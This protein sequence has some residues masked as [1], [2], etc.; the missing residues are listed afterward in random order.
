MAAP[1]C[2]VHTLHKV[3]DALERAVCLALVN[4]ALH[5]IFAHSLDGAETKAYVA[6]LVD[7]ELAAR[8]VD[9]GAKYIDTHALALLHEFG[10]FGYLVKVSAHCTSHV[11]R[12]VVGLE[13]GCLVGNP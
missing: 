10:D 2:E 4:D 6:F 5:G 8:L 12:R 7:A 11:L 13:V 3:E 9:I 1:G